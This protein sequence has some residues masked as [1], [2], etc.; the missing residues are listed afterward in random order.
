MHSDLH[1]D[2]LIDT[3]AAVPD[4]PNVYVLGCFAKRVTLYSQ[5]VRAFNLA[6]GL[7][8][9]G[10]VPK[11]SRVAILGAGAAG[12][13]AAAAFGQIG[14]EVSLFEANDSLIS[15]QRNAKH[16]W[17]HPFIADWPDFADGDEAQLPILN[18]RAGSA[19]DVAK[20]IE[21][22]WKAFE[23][24]AKVT[25][26]LCAS[27]MRLTQRRGTPSYNVHWCGVDHEEAT[28]EVDAIIL[29][30]GFGLEKTNDYSISY[31]SMED[32]LDDN[33]VNRTNERWLVSGTGDGAFADL[34]RCCFRDFD[35]P[36]LIKYINLLNGGKGLSLDIKE[37]YEEEQR[38]TNNDRIELLK[39][40]SFPSDA[41]LQRLAD[42]SS[43]RLSKAFHQLSLEGFQEFTPLLK[44]TGPEVFLI[45]KKTDL[46]GHGA[47]ILN[48]LVVLILARLGAFTFLLGPV[49][50][51][52]TKITKG[53]QKGKIEVTLPYPAGTKSF[54]RVILRHGTNPNIGDIARSL[55]TP[56]ALVSL[57]LAWKRLPA[58]QDVSGRPRWPQGF[59]GPEGPKGSTKRS[60]DK[61]FVSAVDLY[62]VKIERLRI[63]K[64]LR[65][66][67][68]STIVYA[69][70]T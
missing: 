70:R 8:K 7:H 53:S 1:W 59:F 46:Y 64:D 54:D 2:K 14:C 26:V 17:L 63:S 49:A 25:T 43:E 42:I 22:A 35:Y 40:N 47:S 37:I 11:T 31:W 48:R 16:R 51:G 30:T 44:A 13:S 33:F 12:L 19:A 5:Q 52:M 20:Q 29:A 39:S 24:S 38:F 15:L 9:T 34:M 10:R 3:F 62:G 18:W 23:R 57:E 55:L 58:T 41:D 65:E 36:E 66:D 32:G 21:T 45:G 68:G 56:N 27:K 6:Y 69:I 50:E 28:K 60:K 4:F 61:D 67:G